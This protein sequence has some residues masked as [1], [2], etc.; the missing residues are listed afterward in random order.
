MPADPPFVF[1]HLPAVSCSVCA[2]R[3]TTRA[4][5]EAFALEQHPLRYMTWHAVDKSLL[6][7]GSPTPNPC[8]EH[9]FARIH[10]FLLST[11]A[12]AQTGAP[13]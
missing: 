9:Q 13:Y 11:I 6:G 10:W 2:P 3:G 7:I 1:A 4:E 8:N 5:V 12:C